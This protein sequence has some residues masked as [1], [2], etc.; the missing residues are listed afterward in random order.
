MGLETTKYRHLNEEEQERLKIFIPDYKY[1]A[2]NSKDT[3]AKIKKQDEEFALKQE[4]EKKRTQFDADT[5]DKS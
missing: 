4:L 1:V 5:S 2:L 3:I